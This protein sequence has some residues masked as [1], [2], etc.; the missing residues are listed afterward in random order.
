MEVV[1][2]YCRALGLRP[3]PR[4]P[5]LAGVRSRIEWSKSGRPD[6]DWGRG[7][8]RGGGKFGA[9]G[10]PPPCPSP[11]R[12]EGTVWHQPSQRESESAC[13][14]VRNRHSLCVAPDAFVGG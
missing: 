14:S 13:T 8:E 5:R 6:F 7:G 4:E 11:A 12:G 9:C 3:P 2:R 1:R 10:H